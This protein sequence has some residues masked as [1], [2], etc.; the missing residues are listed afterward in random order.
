MIKL[1]SANR[2]R[3]FAKCESLLVNSSV[4]IDTY[5]LTVTL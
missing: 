5:C 1:Y 2:T 4:L 3:N